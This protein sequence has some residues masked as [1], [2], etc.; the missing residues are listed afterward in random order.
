MSIIR[1]P[2]FVGKRKDVV[3]NMG[4]PYLQANLNLSV[5]MKDMPT[6]MLEEVIA[7]AEMIVHE[8]RK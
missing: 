3:L 8:R 5:A 1:R 2:E 6:D 7:Q 4:G